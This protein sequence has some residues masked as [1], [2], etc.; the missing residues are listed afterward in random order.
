MQSKFSRLEI[1]PG[2]S[3][4][5]IKDDRFKTGRISVTMFLPLEKETA[6]VYAV[7]PFV[8]TNSCRKYPDF[9]SLNRHLD[10]LYGAS[11]F[12]D[13][14]K[15]GE[16]QALT[17]AVSF[18]DDKF[19]LE[20]ENLS[21]SLT[22][23]LCDI[24]FDPLQTEAGAFK[25]KVVEQEKRQL[26]E[27]IDSEYSDKKAFAKT[28]CE[29][30]MCQDE[31]FGISK[32]GKKEEVAAL[33]PGDISKAW[34]TALK[35]AKIEIMALGDLDEKSA[36]AGLKEAFSKTKRENVAKFETQVIKKAEK[37]KEQCE[38]QDVAQCKLVMGFR[39]CA[40]QT[41]KEVMAVRV[42]IALF[43][44][45]PQSKLFLNVREKLSLCYYCAAKYDKIKGIML[46][47]SG[48]EQ[49]NLD[50]AR[51][52]ILNQLDEIKNG[53]F[54]EAELDDTKRSLANSYRTIGDFLSGLENF[55]LS[56]VFDGEFLAPEQFIEA[57]EKVSKEQVAAAAK[58]I[59]LDTVYA[60]VGSEEVAR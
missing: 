9:T 18:L 37:V 24:L 22:Q 16:M 33:S 12:A 11:L 38:K 25:E 17:V 39:T 50:K 31:K 56:Q 1:A 2:V 34:K 27:L 26:I 42:A 19:T 47:Q 32:W 5:T 21:R 15:M 4:N 44:T 13:V 41:D 49:K 53:N 57:I 36:L 29:Q 55:Y 46:V 10:E 60:L 20:G 54:T 8:L 51:D 30:V 23:L 28:R 45:T 52:E 43:G 58:L 14:N 35:T 7:L 59:T 6:A 40:A 3:F 48:V